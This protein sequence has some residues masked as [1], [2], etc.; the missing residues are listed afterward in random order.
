M[1]RSSAILLL[2]A[3]C[4]LAWRPSV[5]S[6]GAEPPARAPVLRIHFERDIQPILTRC[7]QCHGADK[8]RG[9]LR[10][11]RREG[12][13]TRLKSGARGIVAGHPEQSEV[14]RR[15]SS[16]VLHE[17]MPP[18]GEPLTPG[19]ID[20]V[21]RWIAAGAEW[22]VHWAYRI[23]TKPQ[24]PAP[25]PAMPSGW[26]STPIDLFVLEKLGERGLSPAPAADWRTLL[27]RVYFDLIGLPPAPADYDA[28]LADRAPDAYE[29]VV[30]RLLASPHYGERWARHWMD[31]V[32]FAET[33]GHDQD[34]PREHAWR[35]RDYL[36]RA[37]N[38][39]RP[40][41]RF[42]QEQLAGDV[43]FPED[44]WATVATGFLAAGPWDESSLRDIREDSIDREIGRYLDRD[45]IVTTVMS[46]F[47]S[48]TIHCARCHDHKFDPITQQEY[49]ALQAVFAGVDKANR[50]FDPDPQLARKRRE[51]EAHRARL[52]KRGPERDRE[53]LGP[54]I[55]SET[56]AWERSVAQSGGIWNV[57]DPAEFRSLEGATLTKQ[58]DG[59]L[60]SEGK[61]PDKDVYTVV[62]HTAVQGITAIRLDLLTDPTLPHQGPGRMDNGNLHL[63]EF[64]VSAG[65]RGTAAAARPVAWHM[66]RADFNQQG[67]A[68]AQ[69]IDG[70]PATAWGIYPE[71][72]KPHFAL[73]V[74]K[75]P[76]RHPGGTTL[77]VRLE[78][79]H[80]GGHLIGRL[81]LSV[82]TAAQ[83]IDAAVLPELV[84]TIIR[85]DPARRT[86]AQRV[87]LAACYLGQKLERELA[88]LPAR[89]LIY[90]G[91]P[92]F[93]PDG[94]F[95]PSKTPR[96]IRVLKRGDIRNPGEVA[97]PGT[98]VCIAGLEHHFASTADEGARRAALA[99]WLVDPRNGLTW[100]SMAN[101]IWH[102]HF[103]RGLVDTPNDFGQMGSLPTHPELLEWLAATL[104]EH[105]SLKM[106]HRLIVTSAVYR[107]ASR[108]QPAYAAIDADNRY[109]WRVNRQRLDAESVHDAV[110]TC[111]G[112]LD[113]A[114]GGPSVKQF[115]QTPGVQITPNVD[116]LGF[117]PDDRANFRRSVYRFVFRTLPDPFQ[118]ALDCPDGS[119]LTPVRGASVTAIQALALLNDK[120]LVR[121][122]EHLAQRIAALHSEP[123]KQVAALYRLVLGRLPTSRETRAMS[124][125][126]HRHGLANACR[127]LLNSNE[128]VFVD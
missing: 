39:D 77:T 100:R 124:T 97:Q 99:R 41:A 92:T 116:Y 62:A 56:A 101:R 122:S 119:Q 8:A 2:I 29:K 120:F 46:T 111:S 61:R 7:I 3:V 91:T 10:L 67:W 103:G 34:R 42:V 22:P 20:A 82:T 128:F 104:R 31:V 125:Y 127:V 24:L 44:P 121:Q 45:D 105:G 74:L 28:F 78:Q 81:R 85:T 123:E 126:A 27:R 69:A 107:Q 98:L 66:A 95:A 35:Y 6:A 68:V 70:N 64:S 65:P 76:I 87:E 11:D 26:P 72:G 33:H 47:A 115:I 30:D 94:S 21:G 108:H 37:F 71:V 57:L 89:Q 14:I 118:E 16:T 55:Q 54:A 75:E 17:R 32:H 63:N 40:Y 18:K 88:A 5:E 43:L 114:M 96:A 80:G 93:V 79:T 25:P 59:S 15:I 4:G 117:D 50:P 12:A 52:A 102:Y 9:G 51:L 49:Y 36:I 106:L 23:L 110:L 38:E 13:I 1:H 112:K 48:T 53:L 86:P 113:P 60:L 58:P 19:Q 90:C 109:L 84:A 73:F 83:P